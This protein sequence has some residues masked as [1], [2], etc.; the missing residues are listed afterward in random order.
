YVVKNVR[1]IEEL[2]NDCRSQFAKKGPFLFGVFGAVD[3]MYAPVVARLNSYGISVSD[4]S[5]RYMDAVMALPA[6]NEWR[7]AGLQG[8]WI[9]K[10]DEPDWPVVR[11]VPLQ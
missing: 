8:K 5:R 4:H 10:E 3:A 2:W 1:R 9:L 11:G 6:W 7:A